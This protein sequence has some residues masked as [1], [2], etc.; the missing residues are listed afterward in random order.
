MSEKTPKNGDSC[1]GQERSATLNPRIRRE[2]SAERSDHLDKQT[3]AEKRLR[4]YV[5]SA[6]SQK[7]AALSLGVS[8]QYLSDV[9]NGRRGITP[10]VLAQLGLRRVERY[11]RIA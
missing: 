9:L 4:A 7:S 6:G 5:R 11:E 2:R 1:V 8:Q 3:I 10:R